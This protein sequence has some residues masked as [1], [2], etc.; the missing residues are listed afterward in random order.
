MPR[1]HAAPYGAWKSPITTDVLVQRAVGLAEVRVSDGNVYWL[2]GRP[3]EGGRNVVVR[4]SVRGEIADVT[5]PEFNART[6]VHEYGGGA[7]A[8]MGSTVFFAN[9]EDQRVYRQEE[10]GEPVAITPEPLYLRGERYADFEVSPDGRRL[11]CV[12]ETHSEDSE[13]V[14]EIV[15]LSAD[16]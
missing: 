8:V 10:G 12:R 4:H 16:G 11:Y 13:A 2:E 15:C 9:F 5:P 7:Y 6:L 1:R 3:A 14:N